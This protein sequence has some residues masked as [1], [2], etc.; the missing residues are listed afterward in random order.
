MVGTLLGA[1]VCML[2]LGEILG[3]LVRDEE[4]GP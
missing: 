3:E 2:M 1:K 4:V